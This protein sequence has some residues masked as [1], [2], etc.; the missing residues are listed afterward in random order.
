MKGV[1]G[2]K[3]ASVVGGQVDAE[4]LTALKDFMNSLGSEV[5]CTEEKF[6]ME[7]SG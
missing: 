2:S 7:G 3:M 1:D 4:A 6:P 5:L